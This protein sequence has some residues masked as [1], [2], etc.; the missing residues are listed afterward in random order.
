[1]KVLKLAASGL[2]GFVLL[3]VIIG[4]L[5]PS[6]FHVQRKIT[7][8]A[9]AA[10]VF[11]YVVDLKQW[12]NWGIWF[13]RDPN[14]QITYSGAAGEIGHKSAWI[15]ESEG[16]GEMTITSF[17]AN[18]KL[19]YNLYF[20]DFDMGST[21]EITLAE[22]EG[23]TEVTWSDYGDVGGNPVYHYF[24]L[25]MDSMIGPDFEAGLQNLKALVESN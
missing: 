5:L 15:S 22:K 12:R 3:L 1:M 6:E 9:P 24:A 21:G 25:M 16:S 2:I 18:Q 8:D 20:P 13:S 19:I 17:T 4:F 10:K 14:M 11:P 7:I 23:Q